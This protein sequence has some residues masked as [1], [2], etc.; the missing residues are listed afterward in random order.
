MKRRREWILLA[1]SAAVAILG[2]LV[3]RS[4]RVSDSPEIAAIEESP[5]SDAPRANRS[6]TPRGPH[7]PQQEAELERF[8]S[9]WPRPAQVR[10][11]VR[12]DPHQAPPSLLKFARVLGSQLERARKDQEFSLRLLESLE[13]CVRSTGV[14]DSARALCLRQSRRVPGFHPDDARLPIAAAR[15]QEAAPRRVL[16]LADAV[17]GEGG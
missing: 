16:D 9:V 10:E 3:S 5:V 12:S 13:D 1:A 11:E 7:D 4:H 8:R 15:V 17:S 6:T 14:I 2:V